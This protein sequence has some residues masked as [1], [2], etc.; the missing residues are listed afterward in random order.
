MQQEL[1][2][3]GKEVRKTEKEKVVYSFIH[4]LI[5]VLIGYLLV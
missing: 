2:S 3:W 1:F 5:W 4:S